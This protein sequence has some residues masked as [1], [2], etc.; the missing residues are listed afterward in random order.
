MDPA[1]RGP[2]GGRG[3]GCVVRGRRPGLCRRTVEISDAGRVRNWRVGRL[4]AGL[5]GDPGAQPGALH[6]VARVD[7]PV[8]NGRRR[9]RQGHDGRGLVDLYG[10]G[11]ERSGRRASL[12]AGPRRGPE[13]GRGPG[14][15]SRQRRCDRD[16]RLRRPGC[17]DRNDPQPRPRHRDGEH[18]PFGQ[19]GRLC[20][21]AGGRPLTGGRGPADLFRRCRRRQ[22]RGYEGARREGLDHRYRRP[23]GRGP[24]D[25]SEGG[26]S[27]PAR[28]V[29]R[30]GRMDPHL[31]GGGP[32]GI[33]SEPRRGERGS[34]RAGPS[35]PAPGAGFDGRFQDPDG[36]DGV[37]AGRPLLSVARRWQPTPGGHHRGRGHLADVGAQDRTGLLRPAEGHRRHRS[38]QDRRA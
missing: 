17:P 3:H 2:G 21:G 7:Q 22:R 1:A 8:R 18:G 25:G 12:Y 4:S 37:A 20:R 38:A 19:F 5:F 30:G 32:A 16:R 24:G 35:G 10:G 28:P 11:R 31:V 29:D 27:H 34:Q 33:A 26:L 6:G 15:G 13:P 23:T 9:Q 36:G 14:S